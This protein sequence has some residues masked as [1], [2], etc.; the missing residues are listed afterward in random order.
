MSGL[1]E[2]TDEHNDLIAGYSNY[3]ATEADRQHLIALRLAGPENP[4]SSD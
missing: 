1:F 4:S 3:A 2:I